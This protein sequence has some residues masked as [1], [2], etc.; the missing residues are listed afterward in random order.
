MS[1]AEVF[2]N[3]IKAFPQWVQ[4][5]IV[6]F[7]IGLATYILIYLLHNSIKFGSFEMIKKKKKKS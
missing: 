5:G 6:F 3:I 1:I 4:I 7:I 2:Y